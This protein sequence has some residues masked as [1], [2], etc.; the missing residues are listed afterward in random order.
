MSRRH[1]ASSLSF[2]DLGDLIVATVTGVVLTVTVGVGCAPSSGSSSD[3]SSGTGGAQAPGGTGGA[4]GGGD[5]GAG[6]TG[7]P[8]GSGSSG[9]TGGSSGTG[10]RANTGGATPMGGSAGAPAVPPPNPG[11]PILGDVIFSPPSQ[12]FRDRLM[13]TLETSVSGAEI[14]YTTDGT[15]PTAGSSRFAGTPI[16]LTGTT[17]LR[18]QVFVGGAASGR[19]SSAVYIARTFDLSSKLP[20]VVVDGYGKGKPMDKSVSLD[21]AVMVFEPKAGSPASVADLPT[22]AARAGYHVRGQSS[23]RFPQ[24][25]YKIELW[26]NANQ[27]ADYPVL[28]MPAESDWALIPPYYDRALIR[29]PLAYELGREMGLQAP[30]WRFAEVYI[31]Y[32]ARPVGAEDY[33]GIYWVTETI[34]NSGVRTDLKQLREMDVSL[35]AL[36]G[37]YIFKFDQAAT[38]PPTLTCTGSTPLSGGLGGGGAT[39]GTCWRDLEVV[40]PAPLM[41]EQQTWL[42]QYIQKLHD[43][44]HATPIGDYRAYIDVPSFVDYL[45]VNELTRNVDA[46]VRSAFYHKD[47]DG[48]IKAGPLWD[49]NFSLAVGGSTTL[50]P[51]GPW[52]FAG[53]RNVNNWYPKLTGDSAFM[54]EV[55]TRFKALRQTVLS[56]A[57]VEKRI[58]D[59]AGQVS[60]EP[61]TRDYAKW[62]VATVYRN[63]GIVRGPTAPTWEEQVQAL[64]T[65]VL[66]RLAWMETQLQ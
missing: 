18:A 45:I 39:A 56:P 54:A 62:P 12:T 5:D 42:T 55:K 30:R 60:G 32:A 2:G 51:A 24:T 9:S 15:V 57:A 37:G 40:D 36:S 23:A 65:F 29:N 31:N 7:G 6:L 10:G 50:D 17:Q 46:Y 22:I 21:A 59:L 66:A 26:D 19:M 4:R 58:T 27:D 34:K 13:V 3:S 11:N 52:N 1:F 48:K 61:I 47:R 43:T 16:A 64:R 53:T 41:A 38:E 63:A 8:G 25:P 33:Q 49:Y 44:L 28:G 14:R 20:I 35:P